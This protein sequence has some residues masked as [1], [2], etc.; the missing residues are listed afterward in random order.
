VKISNLQVDGF[1]VWSGLRLDDLSEQMTVFYGANEAGKTT[2]MQFIR[3]VLYGVSDQRRQQY[4]RATS[5]GQTGGSLLVTAADG[6]MQIERHPTLEG[7]HDSQVKVTAADGTVHNEH[8]LQSALHDVDETTFNN[9]FSVGLRELQEL[10]TLSDTE[11]A[12]SL[13]NLTAGLDRV[14]ILDVLHDLETARHHLLADGEDRSEISELLTQRERLENEVNELS[15]L[16]GRWRRL[17]TQQRRLGDDV[18]RIEAEIK[19]FE[20]Q[21]R[22]VEVATA[23]KEKWQERVEVEKQLAELGH[24]ASVP[25]DAIDRIE[26][27]A[28]RFQRRRRQRTALRRERR[29]LR[30][31]AHALG[32]NQR[33]WRNAPRIEALVEQ[34]Q[35]IASLETQAAGVEADAQS[36]DAQIAQECSSAGM[37]DGDLTFASLEVPRHVLSSLRGPAKNLRQVRQRLIAAR[38]ETNASQQTATQLASEIQAALTAHSQSD[39]PT[40]LDA[41]GTRVA[42]LRRRVQIDERLEQ[43]ERHQHEIED[44]IRDLLQQQLMPLWVLGALG[45][46]FALGVALVLVGLLMPTSFVGTLGVSLAVLGII[47]VGTAM[48]AK[49]LWERSS[50][51]Q[52]DACQKQLQMLAKQLDHMKQERQRLDAELPGGGGPLTLR[53]HNAEAELAKFEE[54]LPLDARRQSAEQDAVAADQRAKLAKNDVRMARQAWQTAL[55]AASL[56]GNLSPKQVRALAHRGGTLS[57]LQSQRS[58][59]QDSA[60]Q[61]RAEFA[62]MQDRIGQL[63]DDAGMSL[64]GESA[65]D[66]LRHLVRELAH[67][68]TAMTRRDDL[69]HAA[70]RLKRKEARCEREIEQLRARRRALLSKVGAQNEAEF[71]RLVLQA[72]RVQLLGRQIS[73]L[74]TEINAAIGSD[75]HR[76]DIEELLDSSNIDQLDN[77][78]EGITTD[79]TARDT[80]LKKTLQRQGALESQCQQLT[81]DRRLAEKHLELGVVNHRLQRAIHQWQVLAVTGLVLEAIRHEYEQ[82]RQPETL[83]DASG[84]LEKLTDGRYVRVWTPLGEE[85]L[86]VEDGSG[87][88]LAVDALSRGTREQLFLS[89]RLAL[90]KMYAQRGI[91]LPLVLDDVLVNFDAQ[92]AKAAVRVLRDF[93]KAGNQVLVF[94]CHEHVW[95][96]F[97]AMKVDARRLPDCS[98]MNSTASDTSV[99]V[100]QP[101]VSS[102]KKPAEKPLPVKEL[103]IE[104]SLDDEY[105]DVEDDT[106]EEEVVDEVLED[107]EEAEEDYEEKDSGEEYEEEDEG[108]EDEED[109][110]YEE[111]ELDEDEEDEPAEAA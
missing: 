36:L 56:P 2:L 84:Y 110:E 61:R 77:R 69:R 53:L 88:S 108:E 22:T 42:Q 98:K 72:T 35:W 87:Q 43:A 106:V 24:A 76:D 14:S 86:F 15:E 97:K 58:A 32:V 33:L 75:T 40:T 1:G 45:G 12:Q 100:E 91:H 29:E 89:L 74:T 20:R 101:A 25:A 109:E 46:V 63:A 49:F 10:G 55:S 105:E 83:I 28:S 23:I 71:R 65:A 39:L 16:T 26:Q 59:L 94:T 7:P 92:R 66:Q 44:Q 41:A 107:E 37:V 62:A 80:L 67:Q 21:A 5:N 13:Y 95:K 52:F 82:H 90:V 30:D 51:K 17:T 11:A 99:A 64:I 93:S 38:D 34:Q 68:R 96:M 31:Q 4:L 54:L 79:L 18:S 47:G 50:A 70:R 57:R 27:L 60:R 81:D 103:F 3:A 111:D 19:E 48:S 104:E 102:P 8:L 73:S 6:A 78:W 85:V 9:V